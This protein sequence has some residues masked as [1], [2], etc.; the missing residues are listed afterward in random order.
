MTSSLP[1][2]DDRIT[3]EEYL[4]F[5]RDSAI[6]H[7]LD[8]GRVVAMTGGTSTHAALI[9]T[10]TV[11]LRA[12]RRAGSWVFPAAMRIRI[13]ATG[14]ATYP[15][16]VMICGPIEYDPADPERTTITNPTLLVEVLSPT[17]ERA[18]RV[19]KWQHYQRI[20]SLQEYILASQEEPRIEIFRRLAS[21]NW[22]YLDVHEGVVKLASGPTLDLAALYNDLP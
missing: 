17:T 9:G 14:R 6:R 3:F 18:D 15:D 22:E 8:D 2:A 13:G 4:A 5:E 11:A 7:E 20:P 10:L 16:V 19:S 1:H 12:T 21:G